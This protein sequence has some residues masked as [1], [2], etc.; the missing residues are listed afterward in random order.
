MSKVTK[1]LG[2]KILEFQS[3]ISTSEL[4]VSKIWPDN[5]RYAVVRPETPKASSNS[6]GEGGPPELLH[7]VPSST[8]SPPHPEEG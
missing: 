6:G 3:I 8:P 1:C 5:P 7:I 2:A 4:L